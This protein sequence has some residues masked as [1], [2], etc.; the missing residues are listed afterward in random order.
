MSS[1]V[2]SKISTIRS[3]IHETL[4]AKNYSQEYIALKLAISQNAYCKIEMGAS[5]ISLERALMIADILDVDLA[6]LIGEQSK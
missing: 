5:M 2:D 3:N 6:L 4:L 1:P